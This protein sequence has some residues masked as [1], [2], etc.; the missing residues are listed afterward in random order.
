MSAAS[1]RPILRRVRAASSWALFAVVAVLGVAT[2]GLPL[3]TGSTPLTVLTSSMEPTLPPGT[4]VVV[5]P[6]PA[7]DIAVGDV[8]TYQLTAGDPTVVS[9]RVV[10]VQSLSN[11]ETRFVVKGDNNPS[12]DVDPVTEEQVK[13]VVWYSVPWVGHV[14]VALG[15]DLRALL[16]P[17]GGLALLVYGVTTV[18]STLVTRARAGRQESPTVQRLAD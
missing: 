14:S 17:L 15:G 3:A 18:V 7:L 9:H 12:A 1:R 13:G 8:L 2:V 6:T 16:L 5:R 11:G 4:L 10:E